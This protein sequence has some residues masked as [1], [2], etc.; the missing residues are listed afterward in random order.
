V[1]PLSFRRYF[2]LVTILG[3]FL[4]VSLRAQNIM[5]GTPY[6]PVFEIE[7]RG[8]PDMI[9][10]KLR[11]DQVYDTN[12]VSTQR[13]HF[14]GTYSSLE[15]EVSYVHQHPGSIFMLTY[16][17]G[18]NLYP[19]SQY[20]NLDAGANAVR[21]K[22]RQSI[23]KRL[24]MSVAGD[25]GSVPGG[26]FGQA[27]S[28]QPPQFGSGDT[29]AEFLAR[30]HITRD[31]TVSLQYQISRHSYFAW[32]GNDNNIRFEPAVLSG[33]KSADAYGSYYFQFTRAQAISVGF[34]NQWISFPGHGTH[35]QVRN[36]LTTYSNSLTPTLT[37]T[38]YVG[39]A[40]VDEIVGTSASPSGSSTSENRQLN[41]VGGAALK[42][43]SGHSNVIFRYDRMFSRGSGLVGTSLR[44]TSAVTFSRYLSRH[45]VVAIHLN[46]TQ[47]DLASFAGKTNSSY[48]IQPTVRYH[49]RSRLWLTGSEGYVRA[50][51]LSSTGALQRQIATLGLEFD[52]PN[53]ILEK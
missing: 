3:L 27:T 23:T 42:L 47:N 36:I 34:S 37:F 22:L 32:G 29:N 14:A 44:Q 25:W 43:D 9:V 1:T 52:L 45:L 48:R 50:I 49:I 4:P 41:V 38:G 2:P 21:L 39:P 5:E 53:L 15:S 24:N 11:F 13:N 40:F 30:R 8:R 18:G 7:P 12:L 33:S 31:A 26:A 19:Q 17:G 20:S 6:S 35:G 46:Y 28:G 51:G 16:R 10:S